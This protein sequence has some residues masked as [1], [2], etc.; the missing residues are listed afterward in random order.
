MAFLGRD[1]RKFAE[2]V[3]DP[4]QEEDEIIV[5]IVKRVL[6]PTRCPVIS[7]VAG[8]GKIWQ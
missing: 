8:V 7:S 4:D 5:N 6:V 1:E 3:K 2:L